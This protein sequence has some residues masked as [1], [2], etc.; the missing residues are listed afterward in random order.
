M[1]VLTKTHPNEDAAHR[2]VGARGAAAEPLGDILLLTGRPLR[3]IHRQAAGG[4]A[5]PVR[6][7]AP[8]GT[9][10]GHIRRATKPPAASR[11]AAPRE[12]PTVSARVP[13]ATSSAP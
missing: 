8:V 3:D 5:G 6:P 7:D 1:A 10:S 12:T 11:P 4:F 2:V 9:Y 13:S